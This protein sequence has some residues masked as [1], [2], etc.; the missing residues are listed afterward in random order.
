MHTY[1]E[2]SELDGQDLSCLHLVFRVPSEWGCQPRQGRCGGPCPAQDG[3]EGQERG[4][5][6]L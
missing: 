3:E 6:W 4:W 1:L 5:E 2:R